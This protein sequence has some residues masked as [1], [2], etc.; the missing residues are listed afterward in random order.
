MLLKLD[1]WA[2]CVVAGGVGVAEGGG[3]G[4]ALRGG[5]SVAAAQ[6]SYQKR[7]VHDSLVAQ[8]VFRLRPHTLVA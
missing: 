8:P 6:T 2:R 4:H 5:E 1:K 3:G 7:V